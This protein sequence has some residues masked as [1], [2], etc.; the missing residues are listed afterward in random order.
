MSTNWTEETALAELRDLAVQ[1]KVLAGKRRLSAEHTRWGAHALAILEEV[2]GRNS[3]YYLSFADI[4]WMRIGSFIVGGIGDPEGSVNPDAAME[5]VH[6]KAYREQLDSAKGLFLAATDH[7][8]RVGLTNSYEGKDTAPESSLIIKVLNLVERKLRKVIRARPERERDVQDAF[9]N[10]LVGADIPYSRE[11]ERI[12]YS[13]KTY[14]PDFTAP[15]IDLAI[16]IKLCNREGRE[17]EII[18]EIND[19]ILAYQSKYG[20]VLFVVYDC[21]L[22]RDTDRFIKSFES[23][24]NVMVRV[25][26]H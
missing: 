9:E 6:Q 15:K 11:T 7:L 2:F 14:T 8:E 25:V 10:I 16:E 5:R 4:P 12:E 24:E 21:G 1:T 3:R 20:N 23:H 26:K 18:A 17:K 13:S 22:I 19:D